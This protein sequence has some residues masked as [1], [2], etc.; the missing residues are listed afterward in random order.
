MGDDYIQI[1]NISFLYK[2]GKT[3]FDGFSLNLPGDKISVI[4]GDNGSGKT[5]LTK[6]IMGILKPLDGNVFIDRKNNRDLSLGEVGK[7]IGYLFQNPDHQIFGTSVLDQLVW[8]N[9]ILGEDKENYTE[10][11]NNLL[12]EF[13]ILDLKDR[14]P[15]YLS[16]GEKRMLALA[17]VMMRDIRYLILDEPTS[18]LDSERVDILIDK[19][20]YLNGKGIGALVITHDFDFAKAIGH[21]IFHLED[22]RIKDETI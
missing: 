4:L 6:L 10:K 21:R 14:Y 1:G 20:K 12:N 8:S 7:S 22:G 13:G 18:S 16:M 5:T 17:S 11:A 15:F 9:N 3:I 19:L 2:K